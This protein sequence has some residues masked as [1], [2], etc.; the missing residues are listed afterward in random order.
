[1]KKPFFSAPKDAL[2]HALFACLAGAGCVLPLCAALELAVSP[3]FIFGACFAVSSAFTLLDCIPRLRFLA[4]P[5]LFAAISALILRF[6]GRADAV[7]NALTLFLSGQPLALAA[8]SRAAALLLSLLFTGMA[9]SLSRSG[10]VFFPTAL[11][12]ILLIVATSLAGAQVSALYFLPLTA[13]LL[14]G[15]HAYGV[16]LLR[17]LIPSALV[18][19]A[20]W[21]CLPLAG[22]TQPELAAFAQRL[23]Q[24]ID[25]YLFFTDAR[26]TFSLSATG[27]Q[28]LGPDQLG[29]SVA[30]TDTPVMQVY[31]SG[32]TLLR[33]TVKNH[34]TGSAWRDTTDQRRYLFVNPRFSALR[35][36]LFDQL[37]PQESIRDS[38][39]VTEPMIVSMRADAAST[40]F[41]TQR[42]TSP[43]GE[44]VVAYFSPSTEVFATR[45]LKAGARYTFTGSRLTGASENVRRAVLESDDLR[46]PYLPTIRERYLSLPEGIDESVLLLAQQITAQDKNDFDRA[47][48]LCT[49]L[50]RSYPYSLVQNT[51]PAGKDFVSWFL[52]EEQR[53]Y[54]TSFASALAVLGRSIGLPTRYVEGYAAEPDSENIARVTQENAHAWVEIYF[55]GF[56]WL[57]FDPT[58]GSG[59]TPDGHEDNQA[60]PSSDEEPE[61]DST[62]NLPPDTTPTPEPTATPTPEPTPQPTPT[63]SP[64]PEHN[65]PEVTPTPVITPAPTPEPTPQPT[66]E[67]S[68]E[69]TPRPTPPPD[70]NPPEP[71]SPL[72]IALLI[73]LILAALMTLRLYLTAPSTLAAK[74]RR[75]NDALLIWYAAC[76]Q[77]LRCMGIADEPSEGAASYMERAQEALGGKPT[78][79]PLGR[80]LCI[81]RY[82]AHKL[83]RTQLGKAEAIYEALL[84]RMTLPQRL[85]L[86]AVR[87]VRG[88][89]L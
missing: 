27:W 4:Y 7:A 8:Y 88:T 13:A 26:T 32:R 46:D 39:L 67:P 55:A 29:G 24:K 89:K 14:L 31:T 87:L 81:S 62:G 45:S 3:L 20:V 77:A 78:L 73:L 58:P 47:A 83:S 40:L 5:L 17:I 22:Q 70:D 2:L 37:R 18:L 21:A 30:P 12:L 23:Q 35:R 53:G 19:A 44:D 84:R 61:D 57:P 52:F 76:V 65:D 59:F 63:P 86:L 85:K 6:A 75:T 56:G 1:M 60:P 50:Q 43:A 48:S 9:A 72:L 10:Q 80:A 66:A 41:I 33:G 82:S 28:P 71:P 36:D 11:A 64:T 54:C 42:F 15:G 74:S 49:F 16:S 38:V 68:P 51:P 79:L 34:Y 25:D 69:P